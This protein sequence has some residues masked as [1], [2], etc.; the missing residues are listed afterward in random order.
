MEEV[1]E[2]CLTIEDNVN[3]LDELY[4]YIDSNSTDNGNDNRPP[5]LMSWTF[6][7][8]TENDS[9]INN[10]DFSFVILDQTS[11]VNPMEENKAIKGS[12]TENSANQEAECSIEYQEPINYSHQPNQ[13]GHPM[14]PT[15]AQINNY[16]E[17][18]HPNN[19]TYHHFVNIH[20]YVGNYCTPIWW[21]NQPCKTGYDKPPTKY[22]QVI[23]QTCDPIVGIA[24]Q[25]TDF[26]RCS[27]PDYLMALNSLN[28]LD[29]P[30]RPNHSAAMNFP[31]P[32]YDD[33]SVKE[34]S[35]PKQDSGYNSDLNVSPV[36]QYQDQIKLRRHT[37][38]PNSYPV[39]HLAN[40][41]PHQGISATNCP[42]KLIFPNYRPA[43]AMC[44]DSMEPATIKETIYQALHKT[45]PTY[46]Q[47]MQHTSH[48]VSQPKQ[49]LISDR[50]LSVADF[51]AAKRNA[52]KQKRKAECVLQQADTSDKVSKKRR[53]NEPLNQRA[54]EVMNDWYIKNKENPYPTKAEKDKIA[55]D[56][57]ITLAQVK[58]WFANKRNRSN[59]TR[60]KKQKLEMEGRLMEI[61][62]QLARDASK[63]STDNAYYIQQLSSII[64]S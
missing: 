48:H 52:N 58:S 34:D 53:H 35:S 9:N 45:L 36:I 64:R 42:P 57:G 56:G 40:A 21:E 54:L 1:S 32:S 22:L 13:Y 28:R 29:S 41:Q 23:E 25:S 50:I 37:S 15:S 8:I 17:Y 39:F 31:C 5:S 14:K 61:C 63:P 49:K 44:P 7:P 20:N 10:Q 55:K 19:I 43:V 59:N 46:D 27:T 30:P 3:N 62:H 47:G 24:G 6:S 18:I 51:Q 2:L 33:R 26:L 38:T 16:S 60:P 11:D 12:V 4:T